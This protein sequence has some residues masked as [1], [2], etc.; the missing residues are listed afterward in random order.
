MSFEELHQAWQRVAENR[1]EAAKR[2]GKFESLIGFGR[3]L[4]EIVDLS[5]EHG[6]IRRTIRD[7]GISVD[8][9]K[10]RPN[11]TPN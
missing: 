11:Q 9:S 7:Q 8:E 3:P 5:D 2:E 6:W 10:V 4:E 1:I